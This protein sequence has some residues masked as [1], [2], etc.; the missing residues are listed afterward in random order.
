MLAAKF[1][2]AVVL[3]YLLGSIPFGVLIGRRH[4]GVDVRRYGSGKM[5]MTNVMRTSGKKAAIAVFLFDLG[6][7][8]LAAYF[9]GL[10][11]GKDS[12]QIN[13]LP[14]GYMAAQALGALAAIAGHIYPVFA[15][16]RGGRG[17]TTF[18]GGLAVMAPA[19]A[20]IGGGV[21]VIGMWLSRYVS[22]GSIVGAVSTFAVLAPL[23]IMNG[24]AVEYLAYSLVG[25]LII[26]VMHRDNVARLIAGKERKLGEKVD[27]PSPSRPL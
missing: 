16:F 1:A 11:M 3:G 14:L 10:I 21:F 24:F 20:L 4:S 5:G 23:T 8:A 2:A 7:G 19:V 22:L 9:A 25:T 17:V 6:K 18:F 13:S 12:F 15:R 27:T 26:L